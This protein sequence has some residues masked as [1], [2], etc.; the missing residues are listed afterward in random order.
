MKLLNYFF[1]TVF[2]FSL[3]GCSLFNSEEDV[4][5]SAPTPLVK[6]QFTIKHVW[7]NS[8]SNDTRIYSLL[9]PINYE[10][11]IYTANRAGQVKAINQKTGKTVWDNDLSKSSLF[12]SSMAL[13]SGGVSVDE[14][15]V[16]IGSE[17]AV[18]YA[19]DRTTGQL[20]WEQPVKGEVLARTTA[21][22]NNLIVYTAN[23]YL[24]ALNKNTGKS[25]W[26]E[27]LAVPTLSLRGNSTPT[28]AH[29]AVIIGD[30][31]GRVN[32]FLIKNGQLIWQQRI[33]EPSGS[34][35]IAKLSN[36][37]A[38]A[39]VEG[40]IVYAAGYNGNIAA[41][42]LS[43]GQTIWH[44]KLSTTHNVALNKNTLF[45]VDQNDNVVSMSK[46]E[47]LQ[48]WKQSD[49]LNRQLTD[50]VIY[51]NYIVVGDFE[52]YLYWLN[53]ENG[54]IVAKVQVDDSGFLSTPLVLGNQVIIQAKNG[55]IYALTKN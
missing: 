34:S 17:R 45:A 46:K 5:Q 4:I 12:L 10:G 41:L 16:Y 13:F 7:K 9:G 49:L 22:E 37:N 50:P 44:R 51:Q 28:V 24:Q 42:D 19:L 8:L 40:N 3:A 47:G 48:I 39:V 25:L 38:N 23:G 1:I 35:E 27:Q 31:N 21:F 26:E 20:V 14:K 54:D 33:S 30:A 53:S 36:V 2:A 43:S 32:T 55:S 18:V 11:V 15:Y 6:N 52:G 29:G